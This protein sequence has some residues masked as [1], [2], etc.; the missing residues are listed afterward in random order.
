MSEELNEEMEYV[1]ED[2][3]GKPK[4]KDHGAIIN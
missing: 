1:V 4:I 2:K 3:I